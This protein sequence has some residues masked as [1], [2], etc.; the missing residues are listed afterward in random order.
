GPADIDLDLG[1]ATNFIG[2]DFNPTVDRIRV[3]ST[4]NANYR[5]NP[6]NGA[7]VDF[8]A[9]AAGVQSDLPLNYAGG[10][11]ADP[12]VGSAAYLN[13][14]VGATT[15]GLYVLD[16]VQG[17][18]SWQNPPNNGV[19][20]TV[21]PLTG[22]NGAGVGGAISGLNDLD[23]YFDGTANVNYLAAVPA[24]QTFSRFFA[25]DAFSASLT[26]PQVATDRGGIGQGIAVRDISI[27]LAPTSTVPTTLAA[28]T[29]QLLYGIA[30]G[31]LISFDS[32]NPGVIR[33]AVNITGLPATQVL[34]GSD[35]RPANGLL[36]A[37]GYNTA[38]GEGQL[39]TLAAASTGPGSIPGTSPGAL[40][41]V[42]GLQALGLGASATGIAFD[43]NPAAD[44]LRIVSATNQLNLRMN[45]ADA[46]FIPDTPVTNPDN[47]N[48]PALS[49]VAYT[50]NDNN[51]A[52]G[53]Q[54]FGYDQTANTLVLAT[55][56]AGAPAGTNAAN[57]GTYRNVGSGSGITVNA[58][59]GV[60]FD[61]YSDIT[62]PATPVNTA[63]ASAAAAGTT[64]DNLYSVNLTSGAFSSLGRIGNGSNLGGL[65]A[66]LT[67]GPILPVAFTW[68]GAVSTEWNNGGNWS[69][70]T[71]PTAAD[72]VTIPDVANDPVVSSA[73][74]VNAVTLTS[75][76]TL[77]LANGGIL[78][79]AGSFTNNGGSVA[80]NGTGT[81]VLGGTNSVIGGTSTSTFPNLTVAN[82]ASTT[83]PVSIQRA[84]T[85]NG[86]LSV[87]S[88]QAFTLLSNAAGT[89]YVVNNGTATL[90][91]TATVQRYIT[92][93]LNAG[94]GYRHYSTPVVGNTIADF[95]TTGYT[96]VVNSA[97]NTSATPPLVTPF[98]NIFTYSES[99]LGLT[100]SSP[101]FDKGFE[102][103]GALTEG[104]QVGRG[105]TVNLPGTALVD[106]VGTLNNGNVTR[107]FLE[108]GPQATAG[109]HLLGNPYPGAVDYNTVLAASTG[110]ENALY[111][112][113]SSGQYTGTYASYANGVGT[114]GGTNVLP[115]AQGFFVRVAAGQ[116]GTVNFT[117]A[118]R[119]NAPD[120]TTFQR[121]TADSRPQLTLALSN[122]TTR[123]QATVY[124]E[125]GAT[126]AFD[127]TF[128]A[129][130]LPSP[131]GLV[132][133]TETAA[134]E[135]LAIN[136]LP[137][138]T[139]T[140][141]LLPLRVAAA[142]AGTYTLNVD[143]LANL[144]ANYRAY[145]RDAATG[146]FTDLAT[147]PSVTLNLAANGAAGGRYAVLF[148]TQAR[149]LATAPAALAQLAS[150]YPNPANGKATLLLPA[151]LRGNK[152]T[153]VS[154]VD[155]LGR[156]VL[157]RTL[158]AGA[159]ETLDLPLNT[160]AP[161]VYSVQ[162]RT[163]AGLV[164]KRLVVQ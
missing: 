57:A 83:A 154:V 48:A 107:P 121:T 126:A 150:V 55:V 130:S 54:L 152:A 87:G 28:V 122:A 21:R 89:A 135:P 99:R 8:D 156:V 140:D 46:T 110:V 129:H 133:A 27:L 50:N 72:N 105:Y 34:V 128:D 139:A 67:P 15:T 157:T 159:G 4:N 68:T 71:V 91:G 147:T 163:A 19:L 78:T 2:F 51:T 24:G 36:Y 106:F 86:T 93:N 153:A 10:S 149:V 162:A 81:L 96:P 75:G 131:N 76:A 25:L 113:K 115:V 123:T 42:G 143:N 64:A 84:L 45:P 108:R 120:A 116:T 127:R 164:A 85:L 151:A 9:A 7:I 20:T 53:T 161:G 148:T 39:Y 104:L 146:T 13:S 95:I 37:L 138:L 32:G 82:A 109:Y 1:D 62:N 101:E 118:A 155:N 112:F 69:T 98:P 70:G 3:V 66:S 16:H 41:A 74:P 52:T 144:P 97:Y 49:G 100:N 65:A 94:P 145:L 111:V 88:G 79:T 38:T 6:N 92:P 136:G 90:S 30:S 56:A 43:F 158:A 58:A 119:T 117:N 61:I 125:Q 47:A 114:N 44:R 142:T 12:N 124:F 59:N 132:L 11:P 80:G 77:T 134:A 141:V 137:A 35:F 22:V 73:Q 31:N 102:S 160:L 18:I 23:S 40:T 60:E 63:F 5:L 26:T 29:G 17:T 33:T 103:P 14:Y